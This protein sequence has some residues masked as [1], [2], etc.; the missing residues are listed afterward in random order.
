MEQLLA[1]CTVM[2]EVIPCITSAKNCEIVAQM[3]MAE[4]VGGMQTACATIGGMQECMQACPKGF[5]QETGDMVDK[6]LAENNGEFPPEMC[7]TVTPV[8]GCLMQETACEAM[9]ADMSK[10]PE[11]IK[12]QEACG[13]ASGPTPA[14]SPDATTVTT[15]TTKTIIEH[16]F[17]I[18]GITLAE[19]D[20]TAQTNMKADLQTSVAAAAGVSKDKVAV[21]LEA[22]SIVVKSQ[23][24]ASSPTA[25]A[26]ISGAVQS[27]SFKAGLTAGVKNQPDLKK[28]VEAKGGSMDD[29]EVSDPVVATVTVTPAPPPATTQAANAGGDASFAAPVEAT[30]V[31]AMVAA[32]IALFA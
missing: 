24:E 13:S 26:T 4:G 2:D 17:T 21:T 10:D 29:L 9:A 6:A 22:G 27:D 20:E 8:L 23:I 7:D 28:A 32:T 3:L 25:A 19:L 31:L 1:M 30:P 12:I 5:I 16:S 11:I 14:P 15:T 18:K